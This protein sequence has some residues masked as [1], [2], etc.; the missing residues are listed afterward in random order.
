MSYP[1][2]AQLPLMLHVYLKVVGVEFVN[3]ELLEF[4]RLHI[5]ISCIS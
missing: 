3:A 4:T 1:A 2:W 5:L